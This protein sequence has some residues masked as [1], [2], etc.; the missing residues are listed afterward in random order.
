MVAS[1]GKEASDLLDFYDLCD[2]NYRSHHA[3]GRNACVITTDGLLKIRT[4]SAGAGP[5]AGP[6]SGDGR[7]LR[8]SCCENTEVPSL[9]LRRHYGNKKPYKNFQR[10]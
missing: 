5:D 1:T 9:V 7:N 6:K 10:I 2:L 4:S 3:F 8:R